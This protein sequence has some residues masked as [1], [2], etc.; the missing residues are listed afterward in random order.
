[1]NNLPARLRKDLANDPSYKKCCFIFEH[2]CSGKIEWHHNLIFGGRQV[3]DK[4]FIMPI[5]QNI[6][7]K[8]RNTLI[9]ELLD[10]IMLDNLSYD[11][12]KEI[13]KGVNYTQRRTYLRNKYQDL[14]E[15]SVQE[16][17]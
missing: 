1:M 16:K 3:Q 5:C 15:N 4:R 9:K 12:L 17:L 10:L 11:E 2:L 7:D 8:A 13:S 6:H 14:R